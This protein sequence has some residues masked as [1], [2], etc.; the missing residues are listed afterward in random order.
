MISIGV[1]VA[2][3]ITAV[4]GGLGLYVNHLRSGTVAN[5]PAAATSATPSAAASGLTAT[6]GTVIYSDDFRDSG[7]GWSQGTL[8][9]GTTLG[10]SAGAYVIAGKGEG[11]DHFSRAPYGIP[12]LKLSMS[13]TATQ[14]TGAARGSGFGVTCT[15]GSGS[16][17]T[18]YVFLVETVSQYKILRSTGADSTSNVAQAVKEGTSPVDPGSTPMA[19]VGD[20]VTLPA[21]TR[22][23]LFVNGAMVVDVTDPTAATGAGWRGGVATATASTSAT[24]VTISRFEERDLSTAV[25]S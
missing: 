1:V 20:C 4:A 18:R 21:A 13:M 12:Q 25:A 19:V 23:V 5:R 3:L 22:L 2:V 17:Q 24:T 9:S 16:S 11:L 10:Y 14:S 15:E 8:A 7:S 6:S